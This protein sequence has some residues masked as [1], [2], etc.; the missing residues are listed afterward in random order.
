[1][2][3]PRYC[4]HP[5]SGEFCITD[6]CPRQTHLTWAGGCS[7]SPAE[8]GAG[9]LEGQR[10]TRLWQHLDLPFCCQSFDDSSREAEP[11]EPP[12]SPTAATAPSTHMWLVSAQPQ[13]G[14]QQSPLPPCTSLLSGRSGVSFGQSAV[15]FPR[16][17]IGRSWRASHPTLP[18]THRQYKPWRESS[19]LQQCQT[20][21]SSSAV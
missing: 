18:A 11:S 9:V 21:K 3:R 6:V 5:S 15:E 7:K 10:V 17:G 16:A 14:L 4:R 13:A 2:S 20:W 8:R 19:L 12:G 1:M